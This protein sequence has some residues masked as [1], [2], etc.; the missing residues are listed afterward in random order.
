MSADSQSGSAGSGEAAGR[1]LFSAI[2]TTNSNISRLSKT[3]VASTASLSG[4]P[5]GDLAGSAQYK[6][7]MAELMPTLQSPQNQ[8]RMFSF[9]RRSASTLSA[10]ER[11]ERT[12]SLHFLPDDLLRD[13]PDDLNSFSL[14]EGFEVSRPPDEPEADKK[15]LVRRGKKKAAPADEPDEL[16]GLPRLEKDRKDALKQLRRI[17]VHKAIAEQ[18][19]KEL[20][21]RIERLR[22]RQQL[23][24]DRIVKYDG[25]E[26]DIQNKVRVL[27][28]RIELLRE[29]EEDE[30]AAAAPPAEDAPAPAP[31][32]RPDSPLSADELTPSPVL[33]AYDDSDDDSAFSGAAGGRETWASSFLEWE[34]LSAH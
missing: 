3:V 29:D 32:A 25:D 16:V 23:A 34:R 11:L 31:P 14:L 2:A 18:E 33:A 24:Y 10:G 19:I 15:A 1:G 21:R 13:L 27:D 12:R 7:I 5:Y 26:Q 17:E 9:H 28:Y 8:R 4:S 22:A 20:E 30:R 6:S